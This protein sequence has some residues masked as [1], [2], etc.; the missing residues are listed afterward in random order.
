MINITKLQERLQK[1]GFYAG[2]IDG[3]FGPL[4]MAAFLS[5]QRKQGNQVP[6]WVVNA[7]HDL[8]ISEIHG[9]RDNPRIREFHSR[10]ELGPQHDEV[11]WCASAVCSWL[12]EAGLRSTDS[13]SARSYLQYGERL[14]LLKLGAICV[15][16]RGTNPSQGHVGF[17]LLDDTDSILLLGGNQGNK[18]SAH[19]V[20]KHTFLEARWPR[21]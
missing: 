3:G 2:H 10:T 16:R 18:V 17:C 9:D 12:E 21:G 19:V 7:A 20:G 5:W 8:G 6:Q 4:T 1:E 15:F 13:A 14:M 11:P